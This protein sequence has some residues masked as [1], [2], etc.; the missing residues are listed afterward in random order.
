MRDPPAF[1]IPLANG[2]LEKLTAIAT[3]WFEIADFEFA[4]HFVVMR[5]FTGPNN[6]LILCDIT[7]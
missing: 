7:A 4:K 5:S 3:M 6:G 1:Q 2:Q